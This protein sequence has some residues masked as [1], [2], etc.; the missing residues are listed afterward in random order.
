MIWFPDIFPVAV[1]SL[2]NLYFMRALG[3]GGIIFT[4]THRMIESRDL[5]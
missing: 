5:T 2:I 1:S 3:E 4:H